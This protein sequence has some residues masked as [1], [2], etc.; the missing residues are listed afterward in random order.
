MRACVH[1]CVGAWVRAWVR[2]C[3]V[4]DWAAKG[5]GGVGGQVGGLVGGGGGGVV[6]VVVAGGGA[7]RAL[8]RPLGRAP[9]VC[10]ALIDLA[11]N[12]R[13]VGG[14]VGWG[15]VWLSRCM[16]EWAGV[17]V[18]GGGWVGEFQ[19]GTTLRTLTATLPHHQTHLPL[20][21]GYS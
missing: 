15:W 6:V 4:V 17:V 13:S 16:G 11:V 5:R 18:A 21:P 7:V 9:S 2:A 8:S 14:C 1:A 12:M 3:V 10:R 19:L 20:A